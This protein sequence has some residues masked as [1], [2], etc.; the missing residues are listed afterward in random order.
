MKHVSTRP[1]LVASV[2]TA[3][4]AASLLTASPAYSIAGGVPAAQGSYPFIAKVTI[5]EVSAC[6]GTLV[7]PLWVL[8]S[9]SCFATAGQP[10]AAGAPRE[11]TTVTVGRTDLS[12]NQGHVVS[13]VDLIPRTDRNV[14]L[15]KLAKP[16]TD[17][18][19]APLSESA[20][21]TGDLLRVSGYGR[22]ATEWVPDRLQ[23]AM[24]AVQSVGATTVA[25][26]GH[27]PAGASTCKGDAGGPAL[28]ERGDQVELVA[29]NS[30]SWQSGCLDQTETRQGGT[31]S[32]VD[33]I[34][35]WI[36]AITADVP[37]FYDY[38][39]SRT[40]LFQFSD[41]GGA[42]TSARMT[43][44]SNSWNTADTKVV[45]GDFNGD[46]R[47]DIAAFY[48]YPRAQTKLWIFDS[49]A[50]GGFAPRMVWDSGL[51]NFELYR[52]T[53]VAGDFDG[54]GKSDIAGFYDYGSGRTRTFVFDNVGGPGTSYRMTGD[55]GTWQ[56]V[57]GERQVDGRGLQR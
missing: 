52:W 35:A 49:L 29:I 20:P 16:V 53:P 44:E 17:I 19:P 1:A 30:D 41:V 39:N 45:S 6:T 10:L 42:A 57:D 46:G 31:E 21:V 48:I 24:F 26:V 2:I 33:D 7:H 28:R 27:D 22:T 40:A 34:R 32:R 51:D 3:A 13:V 36:R 25:V 43:G 47:V 37:V 14:V 55:S 56:L 50:S 23:T 12:T 38:G 18:A 4:L 8:T 54:N 11:A 15:A 9:S 5:G